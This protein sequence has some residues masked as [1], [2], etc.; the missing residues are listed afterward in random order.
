MIALH[1]IGTQQKL[2]QVHQ[3][4]NQIRLPLQSNGDYDFT[5]YWGDGTSNQITSHND[6]HKTHTYQQQG[7]YRINIVGK[8]TGFRFGGGGD[9][10][11]NT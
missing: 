4:P 6:N 10:T 8:I 11:K 5:V 2:L 3:I 7:V 1:L 9:I